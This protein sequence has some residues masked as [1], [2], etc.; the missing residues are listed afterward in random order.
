MG[1]KE[2][3]LHLLRGGIRLLG[4]TGGASR[5]GLAGKQ[6]LGSLVLGGTGGARAEAGRG[7]FVLWGSVL[8]RGGVCG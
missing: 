4:G 3:C 6:A 8:A 1:R 2:N 7:P 5:A